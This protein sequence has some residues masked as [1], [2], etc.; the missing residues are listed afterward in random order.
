MTFDFNN[1]KSGGKICSDEFVYNSMF[2]PEIGFSS[3]YPVMFGLISD[4]DIEQKL[5]KTIKFAKLLMTPYGLK[6]AYDQ[7]CSKP[8]FDD[9][10][11]LFL[12]GLKKYRDKMSD[13][14]YGKELNEFYT[15][16]KQ[17]I[18]NGFV[19][20]AVHDQDSAMMYL[21]LEL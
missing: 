8:Q 10:L 9:D 1:N 19:N 17:R 14:A 2:S 7:Q 16:L 15:E 4:V 21:I 6:H 5:P 11:Y 12:K 3:L 13:T 20:G 18:I